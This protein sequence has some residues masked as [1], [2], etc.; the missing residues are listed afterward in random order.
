MNFCDKYGYAWITMYIQKH[1][2]KS[3]ETLDSSCHRLSALAQNH[4]HRTLT[5][6]TLPLKALRRKAGQEAKQGGV[7]QVTHL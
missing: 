7:P 6:L 4:A 2:G 5:D 1:P 3:A